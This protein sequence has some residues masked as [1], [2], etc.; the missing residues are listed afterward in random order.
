MVATAAFLVWVFTSPGYGTN[1]RYYPEPDMQTC[2]D[3]V[4]ATQVR[5]T[6]EKDGVLTIFCATGHH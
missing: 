1:E 3:A 5:I 4:K 6:Q 2:M